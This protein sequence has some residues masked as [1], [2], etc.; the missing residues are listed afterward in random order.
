MI[1]RSMIQIK[2]PK[3]GEK[4]YIDCYDTDFSFDD[5]I[6]WDLCHCGECGADFSVKYVAVDIEVI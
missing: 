1:D 2:C 5:G 6:H 3:C 4:N